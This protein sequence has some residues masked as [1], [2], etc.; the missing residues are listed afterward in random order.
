ML[1]DY[2][3]NFPTDEKFFFRFRDQASFDKNR[4]DEIVKKSAITLDQYRSIVNPI[5]QEISF[6]AS[7]RPS[8]IN[9][10][11]YE[12]WLTM[13]EVERLRTE[14]EAIEAEKKAEDAKAATKAENKSKEEEKT[15]K[16]ADDDPLDPGGASPAATT[17]TSQSPPLDPGGPSPA[18]TTEPSANGTEEEKKVVK[19]GKEAAASTAASPAAPSAT[20]AFP[21]APAATAASS[22]AYVLKLNKDVNIL[23]FFTIV[24]W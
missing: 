14:K 20:A 16:R 1:K 24:L 17:S 15:A 8:I 12:K 13:S 23:Q 22:A 11:S 21:A 4:L 9:K 19:A 7:T 10:L 2:K 3:K 18:A 5:L 6:Y